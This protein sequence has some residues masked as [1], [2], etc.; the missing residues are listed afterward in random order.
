MRSDLPISHTYIFL[1]LGLKIIKQDK[2]DGRQNG[3]KPMLNTVGRWFLRTRAGF[4]DILLNRL[5][6]ESAP[7]L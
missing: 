1:D 6:K 5:Q 4:D 7:H 2:N 3:A